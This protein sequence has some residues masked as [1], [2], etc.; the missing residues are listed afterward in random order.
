MNERIITFSAHHTVFSDKSIYP[1]PAILHIPDWYKNIPN[2]DIH[3]ERTLKACKPFLDS[4]TAGYIL[5][6]PIDQKINFNMTDPSGKINTWVERSD[7]L[8]ALADQKRNINVNMGD[9]GEIHPIKQVGGMKCPYVKENKG[10]PIYKLLNPWAIHVPKGYSVLYI[11][12][13][14][15]A[16][17]RFEILTGIVDSGTDVPVN[18]PCVLKKEGSWLLEKGTP[19]AS[20]FPFKKES[21]K[22]Q[23]KEDSEKQQDSTFFRFASHLMKWYE[24]TVW[25]KQKWR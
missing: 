11:Q 8:G 21:W 9:I 5:K 6:S 3:T 22:M 24:N 23:T 16:E 25:N 12:P 19:I 13:I 1:E 4:L 7:P 17:K 15:R 2:P 10:F 20:V 18:F 14:N